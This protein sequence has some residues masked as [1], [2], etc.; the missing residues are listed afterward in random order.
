[1]DDPARGFSFMRDGPLDMRLD[2]GSPITA[3]EL[4]NTMPERELAELIR[5][6]GEEPPDMAR[7]IAAKVVSERKAAPIE[8]T[9]RLASVVR[10]AIPTARAFA[11]SIHPATRTFQ[12]L[13]IAVN[14]E[15]GNLE[16]L[17]GAVG[18]AAV[19][20][21]QGRAA[22]LAPGARVG[23]ISFHSLED[24]P[25][26]LR[27]AELVERGLATALTRKPVTATEEEIAANPRA[28]SAKFRAIVVGTRDAELGDGER[29]T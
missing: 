24:R 25:V 6:L 16:R 21:S 8:T 26:K 19:A 23:I 15:L 22:W 14:D 13:R 11:S 20:V 27:F 12:A 1:V 3:G 7:R 5:D 29:R 28:R 10:S 18:R 17:L 9:G 4:V 2:P